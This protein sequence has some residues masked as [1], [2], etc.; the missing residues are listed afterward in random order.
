MNIPQ[1]DRWLPTSAL[2]W[3]GGLRTYGARLTFYLGFANTAT[4]MY[5]LYN[6]SALISSIFPSVAYW[7][8]FLGFVAIPLLIVGDFV[9]FHVAEITYNAHQNSQA[10]RNPGYRLTE[11]NNEMLRQMMHATDGGGE[12]TE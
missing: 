5:V 1:A 8:A 12:D 7:L 6:E 11:E 9:L 3:I 2:R 10:N 4:L